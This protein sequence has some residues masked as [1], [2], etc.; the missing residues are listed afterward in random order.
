M[1]CCALV[2]LKLK[3]GLTNL[4]GFFNF[5]HYSSK[6]RKKILKKITGKTENK[7]L[8]IVTFLPSWLQQYA[9]ISQCNVSNS[10]VVYCEEVFGFTVGG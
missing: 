8:L 9:K 10:F 6:F 2:S 7:K 5:V 4:D 1:N 3:N